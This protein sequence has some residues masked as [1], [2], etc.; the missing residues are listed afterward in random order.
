MQLHGVLQQLQHLEQLQ[1][2]EEEEWEGMIDGSPDLQ[3]KQ[4]RDQQQQQ[5]EGDGGDEAEDQ[6]SATEAAAT[7]EGK[8]LLSYEYQL[9]LPQLKLL[10]QLQQQLRRS[11]SALTQRQAAGCQE[12][13]KMDFGTF[14]LVR[15]QINHIGEVNPKALN[16]HPRALILS[17]KALIL[18]AKPW[19][20]NTRV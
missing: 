12:H 17:F 14:A 5:R 9:Q 7:T 1:Q 2:L 16:P 18:S 10:R 4:Q 13:K 19:N 20:S 11:C 15:E 3:Q 6:E 8:G